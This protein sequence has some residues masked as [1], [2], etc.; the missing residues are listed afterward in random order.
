MNKRLIS[1][2][3][4][5]L[6]TIPLIILGGIYFHVGITILALLGLKEIIDLKESHGKIPK[7][8]I[9]VSMLFII[10]FL[11]INNTGKLNLSFGYYELIG[12]LLLCLLIPTVIYREGHYTTKDAFYLI[13]STIL[14]SMAFSMFITVRNAGLY[15]FVFLLIIPMLND[16]FAYEIGSRIG[17]H[18]MC[19]TISPNKSWEGS[20]G[21]LV[22][23]GAISL[24]FYGFLIERVNINIILMVLLLSVVGQ[25]G[26]LI[27]SK[28]KRENAIKDFSNIMPGHGGIL[29][30]L[31]SVI[32]VFIA[33]LVIMAL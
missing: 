24:V 27:M 22:C 4:A 8:M 3:I 32:F 30:R 20:I 13:G 25:I 16:I 7:A 1:A 9:I 12:A 6:I 15:K 21:G 23:G 11:L 10:T 5:S 31:D 28:I 18:K 2:I 17:K 14:I 29:D 19:K 26:D 33:Y